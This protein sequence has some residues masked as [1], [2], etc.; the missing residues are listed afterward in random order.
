LALKASAAGL[1][2]VEVPRSARSAVRGVRKFIQQEKIDRVHTHNGRSTLIAAIA[3][4]GVQ[5]QKQASSGGCRLVSTLHFISL[6]REG[7]MGLRG[8]LSRRLHAWIRKRT[9]RWI[10]ISDAVKEAAVRRDPET[11][12]RVV[13]VY[14]GTTDN[15]SAQSRETVRNKLGVSDDAELILT[16]AR[17]EPEKDA[18]TLLAAAERLAK[19]RPSGWCWLIAGEGSMAADLES[20]TAARWPDDQPPVRFLGRRDDMLDL[21]HAADLLVHPAPAEPFGLVL[22]EAMAAGLPVIATNGGAAPEIIEPE[23]T[24]WLFEPGDDASLAQVV[25]QALDHTSLCS[26]GKLGRRRYEKHFTVER[27]A[28]GTYAAYGGVG[29]KG[30]GI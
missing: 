3:G 20:Q 2:W 25:H 7:R 26:V 8:W 1:P 23:Q 28:R 27:M 6:A 13:R 30:H 14:N 18:S 12:G 5:R 29:A 4:A 15:T 22:I 24:G 19:I 11:V 21:M 9:D 17:L 10:A 16:A